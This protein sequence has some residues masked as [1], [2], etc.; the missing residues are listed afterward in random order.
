MN[1][2]DIVKLLIKYNANV[3]IMDNKNQTALLLGLKK[4]NNLKLL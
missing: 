2:T 4:L 3:N 1:D